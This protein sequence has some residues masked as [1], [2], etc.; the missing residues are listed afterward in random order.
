M[1]VGN[2]QISGTLPNLTNQGTVVIKI[3]GNYGVPS[4]SSVRSAATIYPPSGNLNDDAIPKTNFSPV[5]TTLINDAKV[6]VVKTQSPRQS[7]D[8]R[9][10]HLHH[11]GQQCGGAAAD[12]T[13]L[14]DRSR[15]GSGGGVQVHLQYASCTT[16]ND[17]Q[18][19]AAS[20]FH[21]L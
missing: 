13:K 18:C 8:W 11:H 2:T 1:T 14:S 6:K 12:G 19:P 7:G 21:R 4:D 5:N 16:S 3:T 10:H 15:L 20:L 17:A 9:H